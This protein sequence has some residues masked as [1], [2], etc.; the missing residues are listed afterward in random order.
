MISVPRFD[1]RDEEDEGMAT[2]EMIPT[3]GHLVLSKILDQQLL[4]GGIVTEIPRGA[5]D[6]EIDTALA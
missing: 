5:K 4:D 3:S 1:K 6:L 2:H